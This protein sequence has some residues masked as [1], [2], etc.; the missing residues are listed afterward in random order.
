MNNS[1]LHPMGEVHFDS[2]APDDLKSAVDETICIAK[3]RISALYKIKYK[4]ITFQNTVL[5]YT[6]SDEELGFVVGI[7]S[8]LE[9]MHNDIWEQPFAYAL[10]EYMKLSLKLQYDKR[11]YERIKFV[12]TNNLDLTKNERRLVDE[13]VKDFEDNGISLSK[14]KQ[15][16]MKKLA[17]RSTK[18]ATKFRTNIAKA[19]EAHPVH[20]LESSQLEGI[21]PDYIKEYK[22][23]A[24][25]KGLPGY[26]IEVNDGSFDAVLTTC[27]VANTRRKMH[28]AYSASVTTKNHKII[29]EILSIRHKVSA[30]LGYKTPGDMLM[31][32]RMVTDPKRAIAFIEDLIGHYYEKSKVEY[33]QLLNFVNKLESKHI[34]ALEQFDF[35]S[36]I[37][38]YYPAKQFENIFSVNLEN[39][40]EYFEF[41]NVRSYMFDVLSTIYSVTFRMS[42]TPSW[43]NSVEV[44]DI[45]DRDNKH[46][47]QVHC[48]WF[49]RV[50][51]NGH[52]WMNE[53]HVAERSAGSEITPH[54][55]CVIMNLSPRTETTPSLMSL[56][57]TETMW[58]EFGHFMH[59]AFSNTELKEQC[60]GGVKRDFIEAPSQIMENWVLHKDTLP[61]YALHYKTGKPLDARTVGIIK[62]MSLYNIGIKTMRQ[63]YFALLDLKIHSDIAFN[64]VEQMTDYAKRMREEYLPVKV[65]P[66]FA[67]LSTFSHIVDGYPSGYY[68]YKWSESIQADLFSRF[69]KEGVLN[70]SAGEA[71]KN[72]VLARGDEVDPDQLIHDFLGRASTPTAMLKEHGVL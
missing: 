71:Y 15:S 53:F 46:V 43:H 56:R 31:R 39:I 44:Y 67:V 3:K 68:T 23:K 47:A 52:A 59:L 40:K 2:Y 61:K 19:R 60:M 70:P 58:H 55:G 57:D 34:H 49:A 17:T 69:E 45:F 41:S 62:K 54:I 14:E 24:G 12:K 26:L 8:H 30:I 7:A 27:S 21:R 20:L 72:L 13:L 28:K 65:M 35:D 36:G 9:S 33:T 5:G 66:Y 32:K 50:G 38:L 18:L 63:L 22:E 6:R 25:S 42:I 11:L 10:S 1:F 37:D 16:A 51:K 48:D 64:S 29:F 4:D